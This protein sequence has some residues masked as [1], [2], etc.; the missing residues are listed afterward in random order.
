MFAYC[1]NNP[2]V[3]A[4]SN[5]EWW[6]LVIGAVV[7][8]ASQ[9]VSDV[10]YN[11]A[12]GE[13]FLEALTPS[14]SGFDYLAAAASGALSATGIGTVASAITNAAIDGLAYAANC[15]IGEDEFNSDKLLLTMV[16][17]GI[18][19]GKG[20]DGANLRGVYK[21]STEVLK[22]AVSPKKIA[23]YTAKKIN[24]VKTVAVEIGKTLLDGV[25]DGYDRTIQRLLGA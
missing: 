17:G 12:S 2:I 5:G 6:H 4:D 9:Y 15:L 1:G 16:A 10:V 21:Y 25:A 8:L 22:T 13:S 23:A 3:R 14:S 18:G 7:G 20:V 11:L 19:A 24:V